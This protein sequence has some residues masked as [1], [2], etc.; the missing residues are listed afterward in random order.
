MWPH[1]LAKFWPSYCVAPLRAE[2]DQALFVWHQE[3]GPQNNPDGSLTLY[4]HA[5][6]R[7]GQRHNWLLAPKRGFHAMSRAYRPKAEIT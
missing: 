5:D 6:P 4:V 1:R 7:E 2:R 3:Q